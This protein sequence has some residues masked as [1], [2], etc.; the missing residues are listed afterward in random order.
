[1]TACR[2]AAHLCDWLLSF[3][4]T[5]GKNT[6]QWWGK[7]WL[8]YLQRSNKSKDCT[9]VFIRGVIGGAGPARLLHTV[10]MKLGHN[11]RHNL[12]EWICLAKLTKLPQAALK[13]ETTCSIYSHSKS[14]NGLRLQLQCL[15]RRCQSLK[16]E[17]LMSASTLRNLWHLASKSQYFLSCGLKFHI[18]YSAKLGQRSFFAKSLNEC[19]A[20][21]ASWMAAFFNSPMAII[22]SSALQLASLLLGVAEIGITLLAAA[23]CP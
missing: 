15:L 19:L 22:D 17:N 3:T 10:L 21:Q 16:L 9:F 20:L 8:H 14:E 7:Y 1:M 4:A 5:V 23:G 18:T 6:H 12:P 11:D 13:Q 2:R